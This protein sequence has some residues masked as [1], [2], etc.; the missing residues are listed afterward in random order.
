[1]EPV[2]D[3]VTKRM[4]GW[5]EWMFEIVFR[6]MGHSDPLHHAAGALIGSNSKGDDLIEAEVGEPMVPRCRSSLSGIAVRDAYPP[7]KI[8]MRPNRARRPGTHRRNR[9]QRPPS[10]WW[11]SLWSGVYRWSSGFQATR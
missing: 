3:V 7:S 4:A 9:E 2:K 11:K 6:R 10:C 8:R 5:Q 1:G